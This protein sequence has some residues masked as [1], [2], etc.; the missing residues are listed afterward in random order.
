MTQKP[1]YILLVIA[2]L[3][4][5]CNRRADKALS[6][7]QSQ[8]NALFQ[9]YLSRFKKVN[10]PIVIDCKSM[11]HLPIEGFDPDTF[12]AYMGN[13]CVAYA[14]IPTNGNYI[15]T[16]TLAF[17]DCLV[18]VLNTYT[19]DGELIERQSIAVRGC[20]SDCGLLTCI[21]SSY[22]N[23]DYTLYA[24]DTLSYYECDSVTREL[25]GTYQYYRLYH[26]GKLKADGTIEWSDEN[27]EDFNFRRPG[28]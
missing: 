18:P 10:L 17:A 9:E 11:D 21:S 3:L 28:D 6:V 12:G 20:G 2:L 13:P 19:L 7:I 1:G 26:T 27:T 4:Y 23:A 14:Q 5:G 16:I 24:A 22:F 15:A 25:P 8:Q